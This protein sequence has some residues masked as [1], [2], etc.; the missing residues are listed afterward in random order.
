[1]YSS[2]VLLKIL[3]GIAKLFDNR[4]GEV[5]LD[6]AMTRDWLTHFRPRILIPI[7]FAAMSDEH[8]THARE[9]L[10]EVNALHDT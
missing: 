4:T 8:A 7:V 6:F 9:L 1:M 5:F 3:G 10:N 2:A